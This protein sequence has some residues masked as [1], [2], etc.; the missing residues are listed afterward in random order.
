VARER[1]SAGAF[2]RRDVF[3]S[4]HAQNT[5][6]APRAWLAPVDILGDDSG[7]AMRR[8]RACAVLGL[9]V[10]PWAVVSGQ[11]SVA[12][13]NGGTGPVP[14]VTVVG[15]VFDSVT[16]A[17]LSHAVIQLGADT[18][19]GAVY[20]A[21]TDSLGAYRIERVPAGSY[22]VT[23]FH[24]ALDSLGLLASVRRVRVADDSLVRLDFGIPSA[25][26]VRAVLCPLVPAS[27]SSGLLIGHVRDADTGAPLT[28]SSVVVTWHELVI[29]THGVRPQQE[30]RT[31]QSNGDGLYAICGVP[32]DAAVRARAERGAAASGFIEIRVTPWGLLQRDFGIGSPDSMTVAAATVAAATVAAR[33]DTAA[34]HTLAPADDAV[35]RRGTARLEGMVR[36]ASGDPMPDAQLLVRGSVE[37]TTSDAQGHFVLSNLPPG[38]FT[39]ETRRLGFAPKRVAV[40]L[41]S[42]RTTTVAVT[43]DKEVSV[44]DRVTVYGKAQRHNARLTEFLQRSRAGLGHFVTPGDIEKSNAIYLSD[45][46]Y[47]V[48]GVQ[49]IPVGA[50]GHALVVRGGHTSMAA[51][52]PVIYVDGLR[53]FVDSDGN[54]DDLVFPEDV[55]AVEMYN[56]PAETPSEFSGTGN[57][58]GVA[59]IWTKGAF[60]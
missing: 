59:V 16:N 10:S 29:D 23:F 6:Q 17:P 45:L 19:G 39:L 1:F 49:V 8:L 12:S 37:R 15:T 44:L 52:Q 22:L 13:A 38:T 36:S 25:R 28:G 32:T 9:V 54:I 51:C 34:S 31:G 33:A 3:H 58:C 50:F 24:P 42:H 4:E 41:A 35:P 14:T 5:P 55:A 2:R 53:M 47:R 20:P 30:Q 40:D 60:W 7:G 56:G 48:P 26:T 11:T 46:F 21:I 43:L 18:T 57:D 27:D